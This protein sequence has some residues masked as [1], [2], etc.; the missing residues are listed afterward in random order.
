MQTFLKN[1]YKSLFIT[2]NERKEKV[3]K[4]L[5]AKN[6]IHTK[7]TLKIINYGSEGE[8]QFLEKS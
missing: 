2:R 6:I 7:I 4:L 5:H 1:L 8:G 3:E